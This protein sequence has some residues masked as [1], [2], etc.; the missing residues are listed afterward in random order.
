MGVGHLVGVRELGTGEGGG[1]VG[2]A[3]FGSS[4]AALWLDGP[5]MCLCVAGGC[6]D[7]PRC[8]QTLTAQ[9]GHRVKL[10]LTFPLNLDGF[11]LARGGYLCCGLQSRGPACSYAPA[12]APRLLG[13]RVARCPPPHGPSSPRM[14]KGPSLMFPLQLSCSQNKTQPPTPGGHCSCRVRVVCWM[15][16]V[17]WPLVLSPFL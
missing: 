1:D 6:G 13:G 14:S 15:S 5:G 12:P 10:R 11:P 3:C 4:G 9:G 16:P 2:G 8:S 7:G 17:C